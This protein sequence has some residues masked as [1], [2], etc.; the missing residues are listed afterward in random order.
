MLDRLGGLPRP[1]R[2]RCAEQGVG[3]RDGDQDVGIQERGE[4]HLASPDVRAS[5]NARA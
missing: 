2:F 3:E 5:L 1:T 4:R